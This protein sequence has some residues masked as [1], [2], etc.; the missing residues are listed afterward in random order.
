MLSGYRSTGV[1]VDASAI[2]EVEVDASRGRAAARGA[3]AEICPT[4]EGLRRWWG[5]GSEFGRD[6]TG[7]TMTFWLIDRCLL[8]EPGLT[9]T[10]LKKDQ[11]PPQIRRFDQNPMVIFCC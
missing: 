3:R 4:R 10:L 11:N 1:G 8:P 7:M 9:S 2:T 5:H 6:G